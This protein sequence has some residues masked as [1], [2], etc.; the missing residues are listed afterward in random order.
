M[1]LKADDV[2]EAGLR[3]DLQE[4]AAVARCLLASMHT[5]SGA[6]PAEA[7]QSD[8]DARWSEEISSRVDDVMS[9]KVK[10]SSFD[11]ARAKARALLND[12]RA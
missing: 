6:D 1:T 7:D 5:A 9:G 4:R 11:N 8:I 10:L 3:L 12:L 2:Y